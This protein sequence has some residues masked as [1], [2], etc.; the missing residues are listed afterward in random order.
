[1]RRSTTRSA[2][3]RA[4]V[5]ADTSVVIAESTGG[6]SRSDTGRGSP[7]AWH[8]ILARRADP[9]LDRRPLACRDLASDDRL[10]PGRVHL[11]GDLAFARDAREAADQRCERPLPGPARTAARSAPLGDRLDGDRLPAGPG[12]E[13]PVHV[14]R[15][16]SVYLLARHLA[17]G[18]GILARL[19][20]VR[21]CDPRPRLLGRSILSDPLAYPLALSAVYAGS[22]PSSDP[23]RRFQSRSS[24]SPA[25]RRSRGSSTRYS[26]P[27][28]VVAAIV[29]DRAPRRPRPK[30]SAL[31]CSAAAGA[32]SSSPR[33]RQ[34]CSASTAP[35]GASASTGSAVTLGRAGSLPPQPSP[36][37]WCS[38]RARRRPRLRPRARARDR[39]RAR[40]PVRGAASWPETALYRLERCRPVRR[41]LPLVLLPLVPIAFGSVGAAAAREAGCS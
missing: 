6:R 28:F 26:C 15:G 20:R 25:W 29:L 17:P 31:R 8:R 32:S 14:S 35:S 1:M 4:A 36:A 38:F 39:S 12:R 23:Q 18:Q 2:I 27:R 11:R 16:G 40:R 3:E 9:R 30:A 22:S 24:P 41:A 19:R 34:V 13:R 33:A 10:P 21:A 37:A 7:A 5:R